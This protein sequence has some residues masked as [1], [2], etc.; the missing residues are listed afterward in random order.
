MIAPVARLN[1]PSRLE[2]PLITLR[3]MSK[4]VEMRCKWQTLRRCT[5]PSGAPDEGFAVCLD[6][7]H[8]N[9]CPNFATIDDTPVTR[10]GWFWRLG[11][12]VFDEAGKLF[13]FGK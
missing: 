6:R 10:T 1:M 13:G 8:E 3:P 2:N 12:R 7:G 9:D 4:G 11:Q 5:Y